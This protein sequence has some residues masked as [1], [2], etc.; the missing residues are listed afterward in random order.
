SKIIEESG[1]KFAVDT[2]CVVAPLK[3]RFHAMLTDS[4]KA[5]FYA[6]SKNNIDA[7]LYSIEQVIQAATKKG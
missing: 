4:A 7:A 5:C 2:C 1:I 6:K 3:N